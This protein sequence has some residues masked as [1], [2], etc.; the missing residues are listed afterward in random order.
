M[1]G[2]A[3]QV[4][5]VKFLLDSN[6]IIKAITASNASLRERL[7][8]CDE[9]DLVTS[10]IVYAEVAHGSEHGKPPPVHI[11]DAFLEDIP[12]LPFDE[13][14]ASAYSKLSFVRASYDRLIAA[15][16]VALGL[17][18]ITDNIRDFDDVAGL[19]VENWTLP[20]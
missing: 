4:C 12:V 19:P 9:G 18:V 5:I 14:A 2:R 15:H 11:L 17:T 13:A 7:A 20:L 3:S 8:M 1:D 16:A 10:A 6:I